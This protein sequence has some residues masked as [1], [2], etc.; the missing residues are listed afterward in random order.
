MAADLAA[1]VIFEDIVSD[2][3]SEC[4]AAYGFGDSE[5]DLDVHLREITVEFVL[6]DFEVSTYELV[7]VFRQGLTNDSE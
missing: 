2:E 6:H 1:D 3:L 4:V 5:Y 7:G